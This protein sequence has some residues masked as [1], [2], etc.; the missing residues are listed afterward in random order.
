VKKVEKL[1]EKLGPSSETTTTT[2]AEAITLME[3]AMTEKLAGKKPVVKAEKI[4]TD[5]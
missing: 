1:V 5:D 3:I 2:L 4:V